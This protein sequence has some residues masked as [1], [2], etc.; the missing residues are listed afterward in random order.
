MKRI[1]VAAVLCLWSLPALG[2]DKIPVAMTVVCADK[3]IADRFS[4]AITEQF[5]KHPDYELTEKLPRAALFLYLN[6]DVND[7]KNPNGWSIA[8]AHVNNQSIQFLAG[9][10]INSTDDKITPL[11][12]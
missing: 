7:G 2:A 5:K 4:A 1:M 12:P 8:I 9:S 6:Q 11:K 3:S 10:L